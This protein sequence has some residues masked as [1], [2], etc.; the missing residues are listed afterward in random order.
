VTERFRPT[1]WKREQLLAGFARLH[2]RLLEWAR[3]SP[4]W[5][6][7]DEA[8]ALIHRLD[9]KLR[10]PEIDLDRALVVGFLGGSGTGKSTLFNAL[11]GRPVS[12]AGKECRPMTRRAVVA[13]H[14]DVDPSF[15]GLPAELIEVHRLNL[16][17][18]EQMILVDCPDPDTQDPDDGAA[19]Q[20]HLDILRSVLPHCDVMVHTVTS[21]KYKSHVVGRELLKHAPGRQILFVQTHSAID[22]DNRNDLRAYLDGLGLTVPEVFRFDAVEVQERQKQGEPVDGDFER[23]R[24]LLEHELS[25]RARHRIRRANLLGLYGW[26]LATIQDPIRRRLK[27]VEKLEQAIQQERAVLLAKVRGRVAERVD[28]N[29]RLWQSRLLRQLTQ[30][31]SSGPLAALLGLWSAGGSLVR[32]L[33]LLRARTP[34]QAVFAGGLALGQYVGE[35]L[36][37]RQAA[38]AWAAEADLGLTEADLARA[39]SVLRGLLADA[40]IELA[41]AATAGEPGG[42][43]SADQLATVAVS[44]YQRLEAEI[45]N[46]IERRISRRAGR[47]VHLLG[48]FAFLLLPTTLVV[49]MG[50]NFFYDHLW[51]NAPLLGFDF[52]LQATFWSALWGFLIGSFLLAWLNRGLD[53]ELK[54]VVVTL[55]P[56]R[57]F[58]TLYAESTA[59]CQAIR[60]HADSLSGL[61]RDLKHLEEEVGG[62]LDLGLGALRAGS[63]PTPGSASCATP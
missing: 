11:L 26:L 24:N 34:T 10:V 23:F 4:P 7:F 8:R 3:K 43:L 38:A 27:D 61:E 40:E 53:R 57:M 37:E 33:I 42:D 32:S 60:R 16:P 50:R 35:K 48:E 1:D 52:F 36:R 14:P 18:L 62:V 31:W 21:Q 30:S 63:P 25:S 29:R 41:P 22:P 13:C 2:D 54:D 12:R 55:S 9:P 19:G 45:G 5:P 28:A 46:L 6:P 44:I 58:D 20:R 39:R 56:D 47:F 17:I 49:H 15:L 51:Y 59:A